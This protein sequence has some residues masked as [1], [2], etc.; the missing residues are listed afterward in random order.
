MGFSFPAALA[1]NFQGQQL[2][3]ELQG[4]QLL[5]EERS[6]AV[7]MQKM[8]LLQAR[9]E[10]QNQKDLGAFIASKLQGDDKAATDPLEGA[11]LFEAAAAKAAASGDFKSMQAMSNLAKGKLAEAAAQQKQLATQRQEKR[12][13][14]SQAAQDFTVAPTVENAKAIAQSAIEAGVDPATIPSPSQ[15]AAFAAWAKQQQTASMSGKERLENAE[16]LEKAKADAEEKKREFDER[17]RDRRMQQQQVALMQQGLAEDRKLRLQMEKERLDIAKTKATIPHT[18]A[19]TEETIATVVAAGREAFRSL[20]L[21]TAMP[22]T[23]NSGAFSGL[24][25]GTVS[26]ALAKVGGN[27]VTPQS[28]QMYNTLITGTGLELGK[29]LTAGPGSRGATQSQIHEFQAMSKVLPGDTEFTAMFKLANLADI[30]RNRVESLSDST[31]PHQQML[32]DKLLSDLS[33]IPTPRQVI[34]ESA[35]HNPKENVLAKY[36]TMLDAANALK[37][38]ELTPAAGTAPVKGGWAPPPAHVQSMID[39]LTK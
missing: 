36:G 30:V 10:Q 28:S 39:E 11:K 27:L 2:N 1:A 37:S 31:D 29:V 24:K 33:K 35:K 9:Q 5:N 19:K 12:E 13:R 3:A 16:K 25:D 6:Q 38:G 18:T 7:A 34:A 21:V 17:E 14:L 32:K 23:A 22:V 20:D 4:Q 15:P 26:Q 8:Q